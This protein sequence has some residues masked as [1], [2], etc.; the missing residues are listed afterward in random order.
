VRGGA[1]ASHDPLAMAEEQK[2]VLSE[3]P[4]AGLA[5]PVMDLIAASVLAT[6]SLWFMIEALRLPAPGGTATAPGL[7]PFLTA[8]SLLVMA[9]I[10]GADALARRR[11]GGAGAAVR[12]GIDLP[13]DFRRTMTLGAILAV[14]VFALE[15]AGIEVAF[16]LFS[17]RFVIG[18][19]EVV[20]VVMLTA[21]LRIYWQA[22][23]WACLAVTLGW[24]AFLSIVFRMIFHVP[25]P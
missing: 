12:D 21:V 4:H 8:A 6:I 1:A 3:D 14:Y 25:L 22:P 23:L 18:A 15:F 11:N 9:L 16:A 10:L 24:V 13:P 5:A 19:F 2:P 7:L 17:L 20:T